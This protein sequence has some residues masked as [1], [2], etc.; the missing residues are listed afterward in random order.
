[1]NITKGMVRRK[2]TG[3]YFAFLAL[4]KKYKLTPKDLKMIP[5][6]H[7]KHVNLIKKM[8]DPQRKLKEFMK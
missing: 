1:M 8:F 7:Y 5:K 2:N 3:Q 6:P 4:K